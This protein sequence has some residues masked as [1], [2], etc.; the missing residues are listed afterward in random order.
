MG[1]SGFCGNVTCLALVLVKTW[2]EGEHAGFRGSKEVESEG[3]FDALM[4]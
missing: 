1:Q 4:S 3:K 2:R